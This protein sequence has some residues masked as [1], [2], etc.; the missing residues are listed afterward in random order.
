MATVQRLRAP[1]RTGLDLLFPP[2]KQARR[3]TKR[4]RSEGSFIIVP[5]GSPGLC[6]RGVMMRQPAISSVCQCPDG[7]RFRATPRGA[8]FGYKAP[9]RV[10]VVRGLS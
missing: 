7:L 10:R 3:T 9:W 2:P 4:P 8:A 5:S 1:S 6:Q